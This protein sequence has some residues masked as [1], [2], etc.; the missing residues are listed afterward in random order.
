MIYFH[1]YV[2]LSCEGPGR[3]GPWA[4]L[5]DQFYTLQRL[6]TFTT[7][8]VK[9][10]KNFEP[11]HTCVDQAQYHTSKVWLH[12][13]ATKTLQRYAKAPTTHDSY[14]SGGTITLP[15]VQHLTKGCYPKRTGLYPCNPETP[16]FLLDKVTSTIAHLINW[17]SQSHIDCGCTVFLGGSPCSD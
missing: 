7:A 3:S 4:R 15:S 8:R 17:L 1:L 2:W 9:V 12:M 6:Y 5:I 10:P 14:S 16:V 13:D 11:N